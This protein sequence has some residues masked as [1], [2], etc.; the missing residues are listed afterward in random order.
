MGKTSQAIQQLLE[1][2]PNLAW[3]LRDDGVEEQVPLDTVAVGH[4]LRVKPGE[5]VPVDGTVLE[6]PGRVDESMN[7][8]DPVP[9]AKALG[10]GLHFARALLTLPR[11]SG[12]L[13]ETFAQAGL[14]RGGQLFVH[15]GAHLVELGG[16]VLLQL[17]ELLLQRGAHLGQAAR[18]AFTEVLQ[19]PGERVA[20]RAPQLQQL[21]GEGVDLGVLGA[22]GLGALLRQAALEGAQGLQQFLAA[23][24][25]GIGHLAAQLALQ[26]FVAR[27][28]RLQQL[29]AAQGLFGAVLGDR[30]FAPPQ[31]QHEQHVDEGQRQQQARF[32]GQ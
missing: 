11:P 31:R 29:L 4:R 15:R 20:E 10:Q 12:T 9:A 13:L 8:R 30:G 18:I 27:C 14:Q 26:A 23:G 3:R 1:L 25:G 17:R 22:R 19:L 16:V 21:L 32:D 2:A 7:T 5:K 6:G 28:H 24:A